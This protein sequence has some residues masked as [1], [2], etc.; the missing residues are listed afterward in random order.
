MILGN[1]THSQSAA[2]KFWFT[3]YIN[4][5]GFINST[6]VALFTFPGRSFGKG[7]GAA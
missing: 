5:Y 6:E 2:K 3:L 1:G 7:F 4:R